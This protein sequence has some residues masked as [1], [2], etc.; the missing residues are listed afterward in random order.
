MEFF[1]VLIAW[2]AVQFWGSGAIVQNDNWFTSLRRGVARVKGGTPRLLLTLSPLLLL[3]LV[4]FL[5]GPI[6]FGLPAF[7]LSVIVLLYSL[8]RG[9]FQV[10]LRLY[11]NSWQRGDLQGACHHGEYFD[12]ELRGCGAENALQLHRTVRKAVFYHGFERWF[13]VVFWFFL[14]GPVFALCYRLLF[15]L[16]RDDDTPQEE[17][18]L[19]FRALY[20]FEYIPVRL[21]GFAF[22]L[23]GHFDHCFPEWRKLS[24]AELPSAEYLDQ[25]GA[26]CLPTA[27][28][29]G[30]QNDS[31][32]VKRAADE[33]HAAQLMLSRSLLCWVG[34]MALIELF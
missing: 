26:T 13:A 17:R 3:A 28:V 30:G 18:D 2:G 34:V 9:D 33:L 4:M 14:A 6:L 27:S 12:P 21:L 19:A 10:Q 29:D 1:A 15:L 8:G 7:L 22:A 25:L 24:L 32:F 11:L 5:L 20:Y 16:A 31:E 23:I